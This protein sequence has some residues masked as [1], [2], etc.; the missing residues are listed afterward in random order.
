MKKYYLIITLALA[1]FTAAQAE[2]L[3]IKYST[4]AK[5]ENPWDDQASYTLPTAMTTGVAYT[6]SLKAKATETCSLNFW[7]IWTSSPNTNQWGNSTDVQYLG[8]KNVSTEW[9]TL[10]WSFSAQ[11]DLDRIDLDFGGLNGSIFFDDVRLVASAMLK[12]SA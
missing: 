2:N 8:A 6:F 1:S 7:P 10:T 3:C 5:H 9:Q 12:F 4:T 11:F